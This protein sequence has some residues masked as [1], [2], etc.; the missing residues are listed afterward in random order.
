MPAGYE[1]DSDESITFS[2]HATVEEC[3]QAD[4]PRPQGGG[5]APCIYTT[6]RYKEEIIKAYFLY[7]KHMSLYDLKRGLKEK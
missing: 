6:L 4:S 5:A 1:S 2:K 3:C 7:S